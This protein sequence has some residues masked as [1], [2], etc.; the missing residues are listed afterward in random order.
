MLQITHL[1]YTETVKYMSTCQIYENVLIFVLIF[2]S[3]PNYLELYHIGVRLAVL[4]NTD[5]L[6]YSA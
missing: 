2:S 5:T 1:N 4:V 6:V 3:T